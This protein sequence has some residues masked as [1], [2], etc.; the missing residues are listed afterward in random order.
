MTSVRTDTRQQNGEGGFT[1][2]ELLVST[3]VLLVV[4]GIVVGS[5]MDMTRL[6]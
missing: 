3:A 6:G 5:T 1:M 4:S 2:I